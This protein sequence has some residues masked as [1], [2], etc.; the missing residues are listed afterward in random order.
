MKDNQIYARLKRIF[1]IA[2][3][4][5]INHDLINI[6]PIKWHMQ[7]STINSLHTMFQPME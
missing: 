3:K 5:F 2:H 4:I 6:K 7:Y 1:Y